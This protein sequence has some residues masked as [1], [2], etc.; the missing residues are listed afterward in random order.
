LIL[1]EFSLNV[2]IEPFGCV[3]RMDKGRTTLVLVALC[4]RT[5]SKYGAAGEHQYLEGQRRGCVK[6]AYAWRWLVKKRRAHIRVIEAVAKHILFRVCTSTENKVT[7]ELCKPPMFSK[8]AST[9]SHFLAHMSLA[10]DS[11]LRLVIARC[12]SRRRIA[13]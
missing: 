6:G 4:A 10:Y 1:S 7:S 8:T 9:T 3:K 13:L 11:S 2:A 5:P 12:P